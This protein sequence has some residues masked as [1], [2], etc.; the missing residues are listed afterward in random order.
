VKNDPV[1]HPESDKKV[2]LR[3]SVFSEI[4]LYPK[5]SDF[6]RLRNSVSPP[7]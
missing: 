7:V 6:L 2:R 4:P 1:G 3:L 5:T